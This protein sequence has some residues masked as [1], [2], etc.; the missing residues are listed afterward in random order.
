M[1]PGDNMSEMPQIKSTPPGEN[2]KQIFIKKA[3]DSFSD[4]F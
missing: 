1:K 3:S 2:A 4:T